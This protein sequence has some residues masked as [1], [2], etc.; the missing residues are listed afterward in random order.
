MT[1]NKEMKDYYKLS[2]IGLKSRWAKSHNPIRDH[3]KNHHSKLKIEKARLIG[4][5]TG[6]GSL[7]S[8]KNYKN[9]KHHDIRFYPDDKRMVKIF[10]DDFN[11]LYLKK[12]SIRKLKKYYIVHVSSK[13]AWEDLMSISNFESLDWDFPEILQSQK[14]KIEW[15]RA[16]FDCEAYVYEDKNK[17]SFQT[18]SLKGI[19]SIKKLL[20]EFGIDSKIYS[21]KRK[22]P[23]WNINYLL[24]IEGKNKIGKFY[25]EIG[26]NHLNKQ[27]KLKNMCQRAGVVNGTVSK[28]RRTYGS[29]SHPF[30]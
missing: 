20:D 27:L 2:K 21:Y 5:L 17:I 19:K 18:V 9:G 7:T 28:M 12:P 25:N 6:D 15:L 16:I 1:P 3:I 14:E 23:K 8:L 26:F 13:P 24:F 30:P 29:P 22:N 4:F 11:K 10:V